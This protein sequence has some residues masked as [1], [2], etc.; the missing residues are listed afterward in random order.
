[1][2]FTD[3]EVSKCTQVTGILLSFSTCKIRTNV[4]NEK[5]H[6]ETVREPVRNMS[7]STWLASSLSDSIEHVRHSSTGTSAYVCQ[8][9]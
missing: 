5:S 7:A 2:F 9:C 3:H 4:R 6:E 1:M 8:P